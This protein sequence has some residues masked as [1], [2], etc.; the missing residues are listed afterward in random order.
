MILSI[1]FAPKFGSKRTISCQ[2]TT[3]IIMYGYFYNPSLRSMTW[4][5][6]SVL[7]FSRRFYH[8]NEHYTR[9]TSTSA[10]KT[11]LILCFDL[12]IH[13]HGFKIIHIRD[14]ILQSRSSH[15]S[16]EK[17]R[18]I[19]RI[20]IACCT[21][22]HF[23]FDQGTRQEPIRSRAESASR[24]TH[25]FSKESQRR[26]VKSKGEKTTTL[27]LCHIRFDWTE[28]QTDSHKEIT[29]ITAM[30]S[31][32]LP[33][34]D[35]AKKRKVFSAQN[36][37]HNHHGMAG[38][39]P[40][41]NPRLFLLVA[42]L[43]PLAILA[44]FASSAPGANPNVQADIPI[45]SEQQQQLDQ[46]HNNKHKFDKFEVRKLLDRVDVMGYGPTHPRVAFVVVGQTPEQLI[47]TTKSIF[48][49]TE[50]NRIFVVVAVLDD[51]SGG[52][53]SLTKKLHKIEKASK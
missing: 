35:E 34:G 27:L 30:S 11:R 14:S 37:R 48:L 51:A 12:V 15:H 47:K 25:F 32:A 16:I 18:F 46:E 36:P 19:R 39:K 52:N 49:N 43:W 8:P 4:I 13:S 26:Q 29:R 33:M 44:L 22:W 2:S 41:L 3:S 10:S 1:G 50:Y 20:L 21:K 31:T 7:G 9:R 40:I 53:E 28:R 6:R 42:C 45:T 38:G 5:L 17:T 24:D 23:P